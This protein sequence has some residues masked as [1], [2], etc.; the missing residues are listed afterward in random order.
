VSLL[1]SPFLF[2]VLLEYWWGRWNE[3][4][5]KFSVESE[6]QEEIEVIWDDEPVSEASLPWLRFRSQ[7]GLKTRRFK[8]ALDPC[9]QPALHATY[10]YI[11][12]KNELAEGKC[13]RSPWIY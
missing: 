13:V 9:N 8:R 6:A 3:V 4:V 1:L 5:R 10:N 7:E 12:S 2:L 11:V